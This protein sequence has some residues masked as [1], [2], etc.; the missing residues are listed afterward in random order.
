MIKYY[1]YKS[2]RPNKKYYIIT[3]DNKK[4]IFG[5]VDILITQYIKI[6]QESKD[7]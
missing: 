4:F 6:T 7:R 2:D 1:P 5:S 3:N